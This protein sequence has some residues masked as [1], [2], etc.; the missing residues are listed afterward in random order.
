MTLMRLAFSALTATALSI[1]LVCGGV[2]AQS[3]TK[4]G[5]PAKTAG[6]QMVWG[7]PDLSGVWKVAAPTGARAGKDTYNLTQLDRLYKPGVRDSVKPADDPSLRCRPSPFPRAAV[8]G[9]S[10]QI[11]QAPGMAYIFTEAFPTYR[12]IPTDGK[13]RLTADFLIPYFMGNSSG[14]WESDTLIVDVISFNGEGW[15]AGREDKPTPGSPAVWPTS[16]Q[17]KVTERWRR[18]NADTLEYQAHVQDP[19]MLTGAWDTPRITLK[20]QN[21]DRIEEAMCIEKEGASTYLQRY[22]FKD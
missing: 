21:V 17:L 14:R 7:E 10:I 20:R 15:L 13:R 5:A 16:D 12:I 11:T 8:S 4:A 18:V 1:L 19:T 3:S 22:G 6:T 9:G 2:F